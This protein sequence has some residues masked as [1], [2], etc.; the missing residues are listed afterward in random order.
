MISQP[1][2]SINL[3]IKERL[4]VYQTDSQST[5]QIR[6]LVYQIKIINQTKQTIDRINRAIERG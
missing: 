2:K 4:S 5:N 3:A 6:Q 1:I